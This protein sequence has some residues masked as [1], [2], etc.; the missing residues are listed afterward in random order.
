MTH[1]NILDKLPAYDDV[2]PQIL[3]LVEEALLVPMDQR[4]AAWEIREKLGLILD[5]VSRSTQIFVATTPSTPPTPADSTE[6]RRDSGVKITSPVPDV[7]EPPDDRWPEAESPSTP[8]PRRPPLPGLD[9]HRP[10]VGNSPNPDRLSPSRG[11][12]RHDHM[13]LEEAI[14]YIDDRKNNRLPDRRVSRIVQMLKDNLQ[15]RD[16]IFFV[17]NSE[18]LRAHYKDVIRTLRAYAYIAKLI[19]TNGIEAGYSTKPRLQKHKST[20]ALIKSL[21]K[22][23]WN[24]VAFEDGFSNFI[25]SVI[26]KLPLD[27]RLPAPFRPKKR[28]IFV[29]TD[30]CWGDGDG[31]AGACGVE[32]PIQRLIKAMQKR[33]ID[34]THVMIQ[35]MRFGDDAQGTRHLEFLDDFGVSFKM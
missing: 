11:P 28:S 33:N 22:Q 35:F 34:R 29:L 5:P 27:P 9:V 15:H 13:S 16:H 12:S 6:K 20:K 30:G 31:D 1:R 25:D 4:K 19:D 21:E 14:K 8:Q 17:D 32:G 3:S 18:T 2:T 23:S 7:V 10:S 24:S 26:G